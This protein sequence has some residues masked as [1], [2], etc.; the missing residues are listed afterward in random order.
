MSADSASTLILYHL[1]DSRSQRVLWLLEELQIPYELKKYQRTADKTAPKEMAE[2]HP[3]GTA[4]IIK[5]GETTIVESGAIVEYLLRK[6][7]AGKFQPPDTDAAKLDDL[8][9]HPL[10]GGNIDAIARDE[11]NLS[12]PL[13]DPRLA[14]H[15]NYVS[16]NLTTGDDGANVEH[17]S[18]IEEHLKKRGK[19]FAGGEEP[20]AADF[21]MSFP[22][23]TWAS[24]RA[25]GLGDNILAYVK[26]VHERPAYQR[27]LE[28]GG[29]YSYASLQTAV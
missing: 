25:G 12:N 4:P 16:I 2:I 19:W 6:Y 26:R 17:V 18:Q 1:N 27:A 5:D 29:P 3:F 21:M 22:L 7:S 11:D 9:L 20:T 10:Y 13:V 23:E 24:G 14:V 15:A 28:K 8:F